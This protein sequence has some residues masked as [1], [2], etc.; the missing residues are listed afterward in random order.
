[1]P[2]DMAL[3]CPAMTL[4]EHTS[5]ARLP[6]FG[7]PRLAWV[8]ALLA[9]GLAAN[10]FVVVTVNFW[11]YRARAL[12][13]AA[14]PDAVRDRPPTISGAIADPSI[15]EPFAWWITLSAVLLSFG[16]AT[17]AWNIARETAPRLSGGPARAWLKGLAVLLALTQAAAAYGMYMLSSF[18]FPYHIDAH[19]A[20]SYLFF[21]AQTGVMLVSAL[22]GV[23]MLASGKIG[24]PLVRLRMWCGFAC[25]ALALVYTLLF[26]IKNLDTGLPGDLVYGVYVLLEPALISGYLLVLALHLPDMWRG[27]RAPTS[28]RPAETRAEA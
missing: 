6:T 1:M 7:R 19:M 5:A 14:H 15:G 11:I 27:L 20:G 17:L 12:Y 22:I 9:V 24:A 13:I 3:P 21:G 23:L 16:V 4:P 2:A 18:R 8:R 10:V 28:A 25:V 26:K